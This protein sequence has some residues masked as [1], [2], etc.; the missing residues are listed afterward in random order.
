MLTATKTYGRLALITVASLW[1]L[2]VAVGSDS[3][4]ICTADKE[5]KQPNQTAD[6]HSFKVLRSLIESTSIKTD[7]VFVFLYESRDAINAIATAFISIFTFT[8][9]RSTDR[10]WEAGEKQ[11]RL[12]EDTAERQLRAYLCQGNATITD[13]GENLEPIV[14]IRIANRGQTPAYNVNLYCSVGIDVFPMTS[15]PP[16][17]PPREEAQFVLGPGGE[18]IK[19]TRILK[20]LSLEDISVIKCGKWAIYAIGKVTYIDAFGQD[21]FTNFRLFQSGNSFA[22]P[23]GNMACDKTGNDAN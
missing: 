11:R 15:Y 3:F 9:W 5:N 19:S 20:R 12:Y 16:K 17:L 10:L 8:L 18:S 14:H 7:C 6:K 4:Q 22:N 21:R 13:F 2:Y 23:N 1:L